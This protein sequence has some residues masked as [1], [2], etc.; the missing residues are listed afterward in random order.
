MELPRI[1]QFLDA[2][3][4]PTPVDMRLLRADI[5]EFARRLGVTLAP[6]PRR[7]T[8]T[9]PRPPARTPARP[10]RPTAANRRGRPPSGRQERIGYIAKR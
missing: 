2:V 1:G 5:L 3:A 9:A 10:A 7:P 4:P 6:S 8:R